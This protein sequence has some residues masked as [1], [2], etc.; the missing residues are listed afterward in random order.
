MSPTSQA[1]ETSAPAPSTTTRP[2]REGDEA[3]IL[4]MF[5]EV[6][7]ERRSAPAWTWQFREGPAGPGWVTV[8]EA[9]DEI[10]GQH[11]MMRKDLTF[12]GKRVNGA[13]EVDAMVRES[14]RGLGRYVRLAEQNY[15]EARAAGCQVVLGFGSRNSWPGSAPLLM[16]A[17]DWDILGNLQYSFKRLGRRRLLGPLD[18]PVQRVRRALASA[19]LAFDRR[20]QARDLTLECTGKVPAGFKEGL[21]HIRDYELMSVFKDIAYLTWRYEKHPEFAYQFYVARVEDKVE[22]LIVTRER[23]DVVSICEILHRR[24]DVPRTALLLRYVV[25]AHMNGS[26]QTIEFYGHDNGFYKAVCRRA[27]FHFQE[28]SQ[29]V[30]GVRRLT[31]DEPLSSAVVHTSNWS[32]SYGDTDS[33]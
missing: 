25:N 22:A 26:R 7:G 30:Y 13:H 9:D 21:R 31:Q 2:W 15:A 29:I 12:R 14:H 28:Y 33:I 18:G 1:R 23:G 5:A 17:L 19:K 4:R 20:R 32:L 11:A 8:L 6:F 16:R 27:G 10:V 24:K 3:G